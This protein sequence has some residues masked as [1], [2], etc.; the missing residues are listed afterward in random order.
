MKRPFSQRSFCS[1]KIALGAADVGDV[2][3]LDQLLGAHDRGVVLGPPAEQGE[4]VAHRGRQVARVA[5]LLHA[6][7]AV[8]LGELLAVGAVEQR[9]VRVARRHDP[10]RL[11]HQQLLRGVGEVVVAADHVGDPH[12]GVVHRDREVVEDRA[13]APGDHEV[14]RGVVREADLAADLVGDHGVAGVRDPK[15]DG[16]ARVVGR[17]SPV[18]AVAVLLLPGGDVLAGRGVAVGGAGL[19]QLLRAPRGGDRRDR[20]G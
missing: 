5:Q 12:V 14:V 16:G 1:S 7:G 11:H 19:E 9:Q 8:A 6:G 10:E 17:G 4:V 15:P 2:E 13:V 20:P 3:A 18:A